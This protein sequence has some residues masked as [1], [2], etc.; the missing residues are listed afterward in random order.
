M[1]GMR[2][3]LS[4]IR[5]AW[6]RNALLVLSILIAYLLFGALSAFERAYSTSGDTGAGRIITAN[7]ISFTQPM[8]ISH[9]RTMQSV[10]GVDASSHA[11][12]FGGY[13]REPA[14]RLHTIAVE[15]HSYLAVYGSDLELSEEEK[16][17]FLSGQGSVLVGAQMAARF[18]WQVGDQLPI[19]NQQIMRTDGANT[20]IFTIAGIVSGTAAYVD[21]SFLYIHYDLLNEARTS[22]KDTIGWIVT[23]PASGIDAGALA[24]DIDR[25]FATS[26]DRT[27]TDSE[28]SFAQ[29]FVAQFG[30]LA[31]VTML[32]LAAAFL[33]L[34]MI[35]AST[36]ALAIQQRVREIGI[37]KALGFSHKRVLV[38]LMG[39][40][41]IVTLIAGTL[42][43]V[44]AGYFVRVS[45]NSLVSIAPG[46]SVSAEIAAIGVV[47]MIVLAIVASAVP[48][49]RAVNA[50]TST[51][52]RRG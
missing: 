4:N 3:I 39:E 41:L 29:T 20:W 9:F 16:S 33:S 51:V 31:L 42:G 2:L 8:P 10:G 44:L 21:T 19:I 12:W 32:I 28:R 40:S 35:V 48:A 30:D 15:P 6:L 49:W 24:G 26:P 5:Y 7:K 1:S 45:A 43:L 23:K 47:S 25:V 22:D 14:N 34:L 36:T 46:I 18:G 27:T 37:L 50:T 38:L 11:T 13:Y 17:S 52:L